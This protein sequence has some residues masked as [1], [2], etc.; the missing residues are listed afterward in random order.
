MLSL[1]SFIRVEMKQSL[2]ADSCD[3]LLRTMNVLWLIR[4]HLIW[5]YLESMWDAWETQNSGKI[6]LWWRKECV[7]WSQWWCSSF[8]HSLLSLSTQNS[9]NDTNSNT[10][11]PLRSL[12]ITWN[13]EG[14]IEMRNFIITFQYLFSFSGDA[15][16][17]TAVP[18]Q[19]TQK[20]QN[21]ERRREKHKQFQF[22]V[23]VRNSKVSH[24]I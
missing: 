19:A 6:L 18:L 14:R 23:K 17:A 10:F 3:E 13:H 7:S 12:C 1:S 24:Y 4:N 21:G 15:R 8:I 20:E 2:V 22:N 11:L 9:T 5:K 16:H